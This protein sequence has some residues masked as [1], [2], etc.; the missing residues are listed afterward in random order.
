MRDFRFA[1][2]GLAA[3]LLITGS[4]AA[5]KKTVKRPVAKKPPAAPV[6]ILPPLDVRAAREKVGIQLSNVNDF[7]NKLGTIAQM[8]EVADADAKAGRL[9]PATVTKITAKKAEMVEAIRIIKNALGTL[10][11]EFRVKPTLQKYLPTIQG[12]TDLS[13]QAEDLAI[14]G[15][16]VAAK[17]P[18]R[19]V[20]KKLTD[21][22]AL[23]PM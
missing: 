6:K 8:L 13:S 7:V 12:I 22:L 16:F 11:S 17:D 14:A 18:L 10:E 21:V 3:V 4:A 20:A 19:D 15:K 23:M 9:K 5:Q 1:A 2:I